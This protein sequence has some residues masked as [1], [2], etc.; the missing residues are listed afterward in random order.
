M[1]R[2]A[3]L[4]PSPMILGWLLR[5]RTRRT[6]PRLMPMRAGRLGGSSAGGAVDRR[7]HLAT[8]A[9]SSGSP[10]KLTATPSPVSR[11]M[12]SF[13]AMSRIDSAISALNR[14]LN[15]IC[16]E[17]GFLE[18]SAMSRNSTLQMNVRLAR[19]G[20]IWASPVPSAS[21]GFLG[22]A[23]LSAGGASYHHSPALRYKEMLNFPLTSSSF[24][25]IFHGFL[26]L[27]MALPGEF[28]D[29]NPVSFQKV[30]RVCLTHPISQLLVHILS[31]S[32][33]SEKSGATLNP[34]SPY[35]TG[36][37]RNPANY[38]PLSP[39]SFLARTAEVYQ[40]RIALIHGEDQ[41]TWGDIYR[42]CRRLASALV[43][44]G[45]GVG[46]TVAV[47]APN[48]PAMF[49]AHFGGPMTGA[50]LNTLN[51]RLH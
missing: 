23:K 13:G 17:T 15:W 24:G 37:D 38:V 1:T 34:N 48:V 43:R 41:A 2:W 3:T 35:E 19:S 51:T 44:R 9:A 46:D 28:R 29:R 16:S 6:G 47:M 12:R 7:S 40:D 42:R 45:I 30:W 5:S 8:S 11:M 32:F 14:S 36:L 21:N 33:L 50:V 27:G 4:M 31:S 18:Y 20:I 22:G 39:L 26:G 10:R 49:E 25:A